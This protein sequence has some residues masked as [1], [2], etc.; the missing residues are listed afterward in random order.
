MSSPVF[1]I[2][3]LDEKN[4][5]SWAIQMRSVL[6][7]S[8]QWR[9]V[10]GQVKLE[11]DKQDKDQ[12][13]REDEKALASIFLSVKPTQLGYIRNCTTSHQAWR[14]LEETYMPRGP[15]QKVSLY[16]RLVNLKMPEGGNTVQHINEFSEIYEKL[17]ETGIQIQEELLVI[18]LMSSLSSEFENFVVAIE[19][20]DDLPSLSI[21]KQKLLEEAKR[22]DEKVEDLTAVQQAFAA[23]ATTSKND[24]RP[25]N[26]KHKKNFKGK[27]FVCGVTGHFANKCDQRKATNTT[28]A[29]TMVAA[30]DCTPMD[31]AKWYVDSGATSHMCNQ[32][33][34]FVNYRHHNEIISLA[35]DKH[36]NAKG[37]G[38]VLMKHND[39]DILLENVLYSPELQAN[40][41]SVSKVVDRGLIVKFD[42]N[43]AIVR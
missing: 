35:G 4:Y 41:I 8:N 27:C 21:I 9:I 26:N 33:S 43:D 6:I 17:S 40:F 30:T 29:M 36:I 34:V 10:N 25:S 2:D 13:L 3:K 22:R 12:W 18:M 11:D 31:S 15:L 24:K 42:A 19:T 37:K 5:D 14:K 1:Q 38:D 16:K 39:Y 32:R 23:K 7:H 28:Q 20:R